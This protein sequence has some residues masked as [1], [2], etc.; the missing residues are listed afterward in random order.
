MADA[1]AIG[2]ERPGEGPGGKTGVVDVVPVHAVHALGP[3]ED[4]GAYPDALVVQVQPDRAAREKHRDPRDQAE[5]EE[6]DS[7]PRLPVVERRRECAAD[8]NEGG[9]DDIGRPGQPVGIAGAPVQILPIPDIL[10]H[11]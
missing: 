5:Q 1:D 11:A 3:G 9:G 7:R 2:V 4:A 8:Q 6:C 10:I